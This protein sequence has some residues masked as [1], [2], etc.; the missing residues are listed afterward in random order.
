MKRVEV[1]SKKSVEVQPFE[2]DAFINHP[3]TSNEQKKISKKT[4]K[5]LADEM[6]LGYD[7][8]QITFAKKIINAYKKS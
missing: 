1:V 6:G 2:P 5:K 4:L 3:T 8:S 7:E